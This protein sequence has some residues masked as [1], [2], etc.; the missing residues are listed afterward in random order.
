MLYLVVIA[1]Q[2]KMNLTLTCVD[3]MLIEIKC[4]ETCRDVKLVIGR[5]MAFQARGLSSWN[6]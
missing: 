6:A 4:M 3:D 2:T 1:M 5:E